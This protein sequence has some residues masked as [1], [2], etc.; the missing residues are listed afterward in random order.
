MS[1]GRFSVISRSRPDSVGGGKF[2]VISISG[3]R[4][5]GGGGVV[6]EFFSGSLH[7]RFKERNK[8]NSLEKKNIYQKFGGGGMALVASWLRHCIAIMHPYVS[9]TLNT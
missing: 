2:S 3:R 4:S 8:I 9:K 5:L 7:F 6:A 1:P